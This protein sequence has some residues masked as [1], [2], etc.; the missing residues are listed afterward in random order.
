V[1]IRLKSGD[2]VGIIGGGPAGSFAA[3]HLLRGSARL[4][5]KLEVLIFEPRKFNLPGPGGCNRCAGILSSRLLANL[6]SIGLSLPQEVIQSEIKAYS[7]HLNDEIVQIDQ[8]DPESRI[9]S[10][11]RGGGPRLHRDGPVESFDHFLLAQTCALGAQHI[12]SRVITVSWEK[13]PVVHTARES[14]PVSLVVLATG[15]NSHSPLGENFGYRPPRTEIM[16][17]DEFPLP[18]GWP[19]D[20]VSAYFQKPEGLIFGALIP[21]GRYVN[22]SLL[23]RGFATDA[24]SEFIEAHGLGRD[25]RSPGESLCG[26][27]PRIAVTRAGRYYGDR[28]VAVGDA[29]VTRLYKDGIGSAF[30]T[31]RQAAH[32][33]LHSGVSNRSFQTGYGSLCREISRDNRYGRILFGFWDRVLKMPDL[34]QA[35]IEVIR[36][37]AASQ[38]SH[39]YHARILWGMFTGNEP[40]RDL[41]RRVLRVETLLPLYR[42]WR[43]Q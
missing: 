20:R 2:R 37:E 12:P 7:V 35:W 22:I 4:G 14:F 6:D 26:C 24:I 42:K 9:V 33:A 29:A 23:G 38:A 19:E 1:S 10:I 40:Y 39:E 41:F 8:P 25:F 36:A 21:K 17:Q 34:A 27:M 15:I 30:T 13:G 28:W 43:A 3:L 11:Y 16:A 32:T 18:E 5:L 31:S